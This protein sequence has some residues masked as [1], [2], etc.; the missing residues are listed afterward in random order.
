MSS[1]FA[2]AESTCEQHLEFYQNAEKYLYDDAIEEIVENSR[3]V[4]VDNVTS[5]KHHVNS[6]GLSS[7]NYVADN[8][9]CKMKNLEKIDFS[10]T[11]NYQH[12]SDMPMGIQAMLDVVIQQN[13][14]QIDLSNN[15]LDHDGLKCMKEFLAANRSLEVLK[16]QNCKIG[17]KSCAIMLEAW[18]EN[19]EMK[20]QKLYAAKND[21][22]EAGMKS[23]NTLFREMK[24]LVYIDLSDNIEEESSTAISSLLNGLSECTTL[25]HLNISSNPC[26]NNSLS[27]L[28]E[29]F[30]S[31]SLRFLDISQ[32]NISSYSQRVITDA[33]ITKFN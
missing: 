10:D 2:Y 12:R 21:I 33:L 15:V 6:W 11:I 23:L 26:I 27:E 22:G 24:S 20:L 5:L 14:L 32:S 31:P 28:T 7:N 4:P 30:D 9:I 3:G 29:L 19:T 13:I 18:R 17:D 1:V 16:V 25:K 8:L